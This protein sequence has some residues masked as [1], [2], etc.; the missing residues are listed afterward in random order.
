MRSRPDRWAVPFAALALAIAG[1]G[2]EAPPPAVGTLERDRIE[3][4]AD[5]PEPVRGIAVAEGDRVEAGQL[6]VRL[7][8]ARLRAQVAAA[9]GQRDRAAARL[10]ELVRGPRAQEIQEARARLEGAR[11]AAVTAQRELARV[12][13][14]FSRGVVSQDRLDRARNGR[15]EARASW[16][17]AQATLDALEE[18]TTDEELDQARAAL[19]EAEA[20][21]VDVSVRAERLQVHAPVSGRVDALPFE[22]G[23]R[24][25]AGA[26][27]A[28][29]L[30]E[31][32]PYARVYVPEAVRA[33][34]APGTR[35]QVRID[36]VEGAFEGRVRSVS[37]EATFT[38]FFA[39][40]ERDRGRLAYVAEVDLVGPRAA[41]LPTGLPVEAEFEPAALAADAAPRAPADAAMRPAEAAP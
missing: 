33:R 41:A 2:A 19:A 27:V 20:S 23:E 15:D 8:D 29:L 1:C 40:T 4:V 12:Q 9:R 18:G 28:V 6:L 17:A 5:A 11:S 22:V 25:P 31:R 14:L 36:G 24:P 34:V 39:L 10:A 3:L 38:P 16:Q 7:D 35:A 32:A 30:A 21:L 26:V 13:E 37:S